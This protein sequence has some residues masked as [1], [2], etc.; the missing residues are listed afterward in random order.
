MK[1]IKLIIFDLDGVL[2]DSK[3]NMKLAW[4]YVKKNH[5]IKVSFYDYFKNIG[6]PFEDI[7]FKLG[8]K[9]NIQKIKKT[10]SM[11]SIKYFNNIK[12][13]KNAKSVIKELGKDYYLAVLTSKDKKRT[14]LI[15]KKFKLKFNSINC[16]IEGKKGKP[17]PWQI[18]KVIKKY[19]LKKNQVIYIGDTKIDQK[20]AKNAGIKFLYTRYGYGGYQGLKNI[21][22][23]LKNIKEIYNYL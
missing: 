14:N 10:Y 17:N 12:L 23:S 7:L 13:F 3:L 15:V 11:G 16:P 6:I 21:K 22:Y 8:I 5:K 18:K 4:D 20:T 9:N 2:I 19:K 1:K